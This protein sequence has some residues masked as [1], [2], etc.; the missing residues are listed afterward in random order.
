MKCLIKRSKESLHFFKEHIL[1][2]ECGGNIV[3]S[4]MLLHSGL[5]ENTGRWRKGLPCNKLAAWL[6]YVDVQVFWGGKNYID[7]KSVT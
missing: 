2:L 5:I 3:L 1:C 6:D 4:L 7:A